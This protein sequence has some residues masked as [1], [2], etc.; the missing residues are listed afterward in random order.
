[1]DEARAYP[2]FCY[3]M[4]TGVICRYLFSNRS[5]RDDAY[6]FMSTPC[7]RCR[8]STFVLNESEPIFDTL[9]EFVDYLNRV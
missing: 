9:E 8:K 4:G 5:A 2:L 3:T 7:D 6:M 1:M